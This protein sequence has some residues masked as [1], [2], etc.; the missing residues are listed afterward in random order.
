M[1]EQI[2][3]FEVTGPEDLE[4]TPTEIADLKT[5]FR[6]ALVEVFEARNEEGQDAVSGDIEFV[7]GGGSEMS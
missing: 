3:E 2:V 5:R 7:P 6:A 1:S 4:L